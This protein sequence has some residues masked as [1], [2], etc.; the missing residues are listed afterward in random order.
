MKSINIKH[1]KVSSNG[2]ISFSFTY[3]KSIKQ[4]VFY[5]KDFINSQF[6]I[7]PTKN[8]AFQSSYNTFYKSKY[9]F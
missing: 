9:K 2:A 4:V 6:S 8:Q 1:I 3:L 7:K 5:E